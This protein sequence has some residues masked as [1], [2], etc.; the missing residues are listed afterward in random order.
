MPEYITVEYQNATTILTY[1][2]PTQRN[3][4]SEALRQE[5]IAALKAF[6]NDKNQRALVITGSGDRAFCAG[7][8]L[9][10]TKTLNAENAAEWQE[11]LRVYMASIRELDKPCIAAINGAATGAG[12]YTALLCDIRIAHADIKMG[13]P[14]INVGFPSIIGTRLMYM[15]LGHSATVEFSLSGRLLSG[16]E[17]LERQLVTELVSSDQVMPRAL[18]W[19]ADLASKPPLAMKLTKQALREYTQDIFDGAIDTGKRLQPIA[20][21]SGEPQR[22]TAKFLTRKR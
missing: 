20:F 6:N 7:Q 1:N 17:A 10:E 9:K 2:R 12:F 16:I 4:L 13:Q 8:D 3:A 21:E 22:M 19:A 15:T 5:F 14:E 11:Q 18:E